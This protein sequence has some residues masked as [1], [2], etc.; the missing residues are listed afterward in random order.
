MPNTPL[1]PVYAIDP[2]SGER[3]RYASMKSAGAA[4]GI[5]PSRISAACVTGYRCCGLYWIKETDMEED[6]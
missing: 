2:S 5:D 6:G 1:K 4:M 3:I